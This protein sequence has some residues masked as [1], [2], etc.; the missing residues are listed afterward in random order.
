M[1][2]TA[3]SPA[4]FGLLQHPPSHSSCGFT[5]STRGWLVRPGTCSAGFKNP[6]SIWPVPSHTAN[7]PDSSRCRIGSVSTQPLFLYIHSFKFIKT[8]FRLACLLYFLR[9]SR[10]DRRYSGKQLYP[11]YGLS[12]NGKHNLL[13]TMWND[14]SDFLFRQVVNLIMAS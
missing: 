10:Y 12:W 13:Q 3:P 7:L 5:W 9:L 11:L 14:S 2:Q 8:V 6:P 4:S 1:Y